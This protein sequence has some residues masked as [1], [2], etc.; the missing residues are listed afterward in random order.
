ILRGTGQLL[1]LKGRSAA[2]EITKAQKK[3]NKYGARQTE[4]LIAGES[5]L[6]EPTTVVRVSL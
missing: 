4:I 3:L 6:E 1:A 2:D 5:L